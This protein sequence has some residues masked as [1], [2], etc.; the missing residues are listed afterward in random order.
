[1]NISSKEEFY[2]AKEN[3]NFM[4]F[5]FNTNKDKKKVLNP[6]K[7]AFTWT[8][9]FSSTRIDQIWASNYL[10]SELLAADITEMDTL[11]GS[12]YN[13]VLV[14]LDLIPLTS[15]YNLIKIKKN[16]AKRTIFLYNDAKEDDWNSYHTDLDISLS[17]NTKTEYLKQYPQISSQEYSQEKC[18]QHGYKQMKTQA[19]VEIIQ[20]SG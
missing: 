9:S 20:K 1:M 14:L 19:Q 10:S 5:W 7:K 3:L 11:T 4:S 12:D 8:N 6:T 15:N 2:I 13:I 18:S 17:N 16:Q